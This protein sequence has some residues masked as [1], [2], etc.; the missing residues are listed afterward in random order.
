MSFKLT[1]ATVSNAHNNLTG[2]IDS[3][4]HNTARWLHALLDAE[5][6]DLVEQEWDCAVEGASPPNAEPLVPYEVSDVELISDDDTEPEDSDDTLSVTSNPTTTSKKSFMNSQST[7]VPALQRGFSFYG[8]PPTNTTT[9]TITK[10][11]PK[12]QASGP[13]T[14]HVTELADF[15]GL[16]MGQVT[17]HTATS[18]GS[19]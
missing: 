3:L 16:K 12:P 7:T 13:Q 1:S 6:G 4:D 8:L 17:T 15:S 10:P 18:R 2:A 5:E 14:Y 11:A 19:D 9:P